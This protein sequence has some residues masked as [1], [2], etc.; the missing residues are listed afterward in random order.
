MLLNYFEQC[1]VCNKTSKNCLE[2]QVKWY[3]YE[4]PDEF[5]MFLRS[6][7][8]VYYINWILSAHSCMSLND[9]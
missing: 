2:R 4:S 3:I 7:M 1:E 9:F 6:C 5:L 8:G